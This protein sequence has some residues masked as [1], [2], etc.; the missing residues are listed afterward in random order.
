MS[1]RSVRINEA[2]NPAVQQEENIAPARAAGRGSR[3]GGRGGAAAG[4]IQNT[5]VK[6]ITN[7][8]AYLLLL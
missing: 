7:I 2:G 3:D 8:L 5:N 4:Q 1:R 6:R